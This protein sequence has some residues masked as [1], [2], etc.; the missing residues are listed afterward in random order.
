MNY[1]NS[2]Y[3]MYKNYISDTNNTNDINKLNHTSS[4]IDAEYI[5]IKK[6]KKKPI[7]CNSFFTKYKINKI[8]NLKLNNKIDT[9]EYK[10]NKMNDKLNIYN[11]KKDELNIYNIKK[12]EQIEKQF[13]Y[14]LKYVGIGL[15]FSTVLYK[16]YYKYSQ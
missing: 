1:L 3:N 11:I 9:I 15:L 10:I 16:H 7:S 5:E 13:I 2:V 12:N 6:L 14:I 4:C 8:Y